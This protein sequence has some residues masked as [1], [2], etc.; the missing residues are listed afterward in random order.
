MGDRTA[1]RLDALSPEEK[2]VLLAQLYASQVQKPKTA[3][4]SLAQERVLSL[5]QLEPDSS[6]YNITTAYRLQG[7]LD[8][9]LLQQALTQ[10]VRRHAVLRTAFAAVEG[11]PAQLIAPDV[12][13]RLVEHS[14]ESSAATAQEQ[15]IQQLI[16][17]QGGQPFD[18]S[19]AP[20]LR[21][22]L[23]RLAEE[24]H[25]LVLT[26]HRL[27][28]D[29]QCWPVLIAELIALCAAR[30]RGAAAL[31]ALPL[32]YAD[33]A[34]W[35]REW[36]KGDALETQLAYWRERLSGKIRLLQLPTDHPRS[37]A[38]SRSA[39]RTFTLP[40]D[41]S[42]ALRSLSRQAGVSLFVT[43]LAAF[44]ALLYRY[45]AQTDFVV[46]SSVAGRNRPELNGLI[47]LFAN[48][49][50]LRSDLAD[51]PTFRELLGR[52][53]ETA[54]GAYAHQDVPFEQI[55]EGMQIE[56][57]QRY[58]AIFQVMLVFW[59]EPL[60]PVEWP[61]LILSPLD[62]D[63]KPADFDLLLH[64]THTRPAMTVMLRYKADLFE[65]ATIARLFERFERVLAE[66][67]AD[68]ER[69][70]SEPAPAK[71]EAE[72][73][74]VTGAVPLL[75]SQSAY[76]RAPDRWVNM[77]EAVELREH[78]NPVLL[79]RAVRHILEHH[80]ALRTRFVYDG[81]W[82]Q[83]IA[84]PDG[85]AP[86]TFVDLAQLSAARRE[87]MIATALA[88]L[89]SHLGPLESALIHVTLFEL[90][91]ERP[92][93]LVFTVHHIISD[94]ASLPIL[95]EDLHTAYRQI[96]RSESVRLPAKT[97]SVKAWAEQL[98]GYLRSS[99]FQERLNREL[100][101][102]Q[103]PG[104]PLPLDNAEGRQQNTLAST[105]QVQVSLSADETGILLKEFPKIHKIWLI[106]I[107]LTALTH[108]LTR[109]SG[110][111]RVTL[112]IVDAGRNLELPGAEA[113]DLSR[114]VGCLFVPG[115]LLLEQPDADDPLAALHLVREQLQRFP[116]YGLSVGMAQ[117]RDRYPE[118]RLVG[119]AELRL[120]YLGQ[121]SLP[122]I[123]GWSPRTSTAL[124]DFV[125]NRRHAATDRN[126]VLLNC[127]AIIL[128]GRLVVGWEYS[129]NIHRR[130]TIE[131]LAGDF[132]DAL[133]ALASRSQLLREQIGE[134][135]R[136]A[137]A[138][139]APRT[140]V[141]EAL[142]R[143][144]AEAL[145]HERVGMHD[146]FFELGG[147]SLT[148][149]RIISK[150]NQAGLSITP[151]KLFENQTVAQL[152]ATL[153]PTLIERNAADRAT[154]PVPL[155]PAQCW[156]FEPP[157]L[158]PREFDQFDQLLFVEMRAHVDPALLDAALRSLCTHHDA[159][160]LSFEYTA[161]GWR[162]AYA[163]SAASAPLTRID[164]S[165][166]AER[167]QDAA[168]ERAT[169]ELRAGLRLATGPLLRVALFDLGARRTARALLL[170][171][172]LIADPASWRIVLE[173][174]GSAYRQLRASE[175]ACLPPKT[176]SFGRWAEQLA[177]SAR[178]H[179]VAQTRGDWLDEAL[180]RVAPLPVDQ[181][182]GANTPASA[183][184]IRESL[185]AD[186]TH[187]LLHE[188]PGAY[189]TTTEEMLLAAL[190][191]V[192]A[193]WTGEHS[194]LLDL[195]SCGREAS[196]GVDCS[197]TLGWLTP[198]YPA[199]L[200]LRTASEPR[201]TLV[202]VKEGLRRIP[203]KGVGY[204][205]LRYLSGD[206]SLTEALAALPRPEVVFS[207]LGRLEDVL[208]ESPV[209][210]A[211]IAFEGARGGVGGARRHVLQISAS[212]SAGR[213][214]TTWTYSRNLHQH[215]TINR[216][217]ARFMDA[218]RALIAHCQAPDAGAYT[219]SDFADF[220]WDA[221]YLGDI[222]VEIDKA[223]R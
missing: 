118:A 190:A 1:G 39:L 7:P 14:L 192:F 95:L 64:V 163:G 181:A 135:A 183:Q 157:T 18:L 103:T 191:Q 201:E 16:L 143:I 52:V 196:A 155:T 203:D 175:A 197:R 21:A 38:Q 114:T 80:D 145:G 168:I 26:T 218:L 19:R 152:A 204:G 3:P 35:Q 219:P 49:L 60:P 106:D 69:R 134:A 170:M 41:L 193:E 216:L 102:F 36:L 164:L 56:R 11:R 20:L 107:L 8:M 208:A 150:A 111:R 76:L 67:V 42:D 90:G 141:E 198:V 113:I 79:R 172:R 128:D 165:A 133:R 174:L 176:A 34:A 91:A 63:T 189:Q 37:A 30:A 45:T 217:A 81:E 66:I 144:W 167:E 184:T 187:A 108:A 158:D 87:G 136:P 12:P 96:E 71:A 50:A 151:K 75:P 93:Y 2:R 28:F 54:A 40:A 154:G 6:A 200:D 194:L 94:N 88:S 72:Q 5:C 55:L 146:N 98:E 117:Q 86:C 221:Q 121:P 178:S 100:A 57:D 124:E 148:G 48:L 15:R 222:A 212:V 77:V 24:D 61:G 207:Y 27:V 22:S 138:Y 78:L 220:K 59:P 92:G 211:S 179:T 25:V 186:E 180:R 33:Y 97:T 84:A 4:L 70:V 85:A 213:L 73:G 129:R 68:P 137:C 140:P 31:P 105:A 159:L 132:L 46:F 126:P 131:R 166:L 149:L 156:F 223:L 58:A 17:H 122:N 120:N 116:T 13:L 125:A 139:V 182:A 10:I 110:A 171:H 115:V 65:T 9:A 169:L 89:Q 53:R 185:D 74:I 123:A 195:E 101:L 127:T 210:G 161:S 109:W 82:R 83:S 99:T 130:S 112:S 147:D 32:Q 43:L 162:Q 214:H 62:I 23:L 142:A 209:F 44:Q 51:N 188:A 177:A 104:A 199:L 215:V 206:P 29:G 119:P 205:M 173:D 47:G 160:R 153:E 202:S